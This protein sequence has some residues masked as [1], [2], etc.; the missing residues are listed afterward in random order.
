MRGEI[1][2]LN[3]KD[4]KELMT[5]ISLA[6]EKS[7]VNPKS[8]WIEIET[9]SDKLN[10]KV[11]NYDYYLQ[12]S[13]NAEV[14][15]ALHV[16]ILAD[17]FIPLVAKLD[18]DTIDIEE[19]LNALVITTSSSTYNFP[20]IKELGKTKTLDKIEF[21]ATTSP[22]NVSGVDLATIA[23]TNANGLMGAIYSKDIQQYIYVD[24]LGAI[25]F[26]ENIYV[27]NFANKIDGEFKMLLTSTQARLLEIFSNEE[28]VTMEFEHKPT[29]NDT[30]TETNKVC[31]KSPSA[32]LILIAQDMSKTESFPSIKLRTLA[33][34]PEQ[35]HIVV[36]KKAL[37]K[38]LA[39]LMVFDKKFDIT[40]LDYSKLVFKENELELISIKN[41]NVEKIP[42]I[43]SQNVI[44]HESM[45]RFADL[46]KQL[47]AITSK[48]IDISYGSKPAIV[49][50]GNI[51]QLIP[52]IR[53]V[54]A[55]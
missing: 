53:V 28:N 24:N 9:V 43:S 50:N 48:E 19:K 52:E 46:V 14:D 6:I 34:N 51:K 29:F 45:I 40:V 18:E 3:I 17:T 30:P 10:F 16:T 20:V 37:D 36:D 31:I 47:K 22:I 26:T 1:M 54:K 7:K 41:K 13:V 5:K 42:Y 8:G 2:K 11:S 21:N 38:A 27:N 4:L 33:D 55:V 49:I 12:A 39:R 32:Q 23:Y 35:T 44:E 25:T 15:S